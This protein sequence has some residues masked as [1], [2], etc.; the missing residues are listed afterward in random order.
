MDDAVRRR[1]TANIPAKL[2][3]Q[4]QEATG[5]GITATVIAGL[6]ALASARNGSALRM[7]RGKVGFELDLAKT[8][9]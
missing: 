3:K 6:E 9:R 5:L 4:A 7:L 8:R 1:I 2:L